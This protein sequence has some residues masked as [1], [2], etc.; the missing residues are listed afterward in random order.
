MALLL[1]FLSG[2]TSIA[3]L[4]DRSRRIEREW[5]LEYQ[6][7]ED[8]LRFRVV[9]APAIVVYEEMRRTIIDLGLP[10]V[11]ESFADGVL[12]A[13]NNAPS[14]LTKEEW[15]EVKRKEDPQMKDIGGSLLVL[16]ED[17]SNFVITLLAVVK[18]FGDISVV[19]LEYE[20]D[21]PK[22]RRMG[23]LLS[24]KAPPSAVRIASQKFWTFLQL[25]LEKLK[26][27][28]PRRRQ[29]KEFEI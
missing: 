15:L 25:R 24:R 6:K 9:E 14:P 1:L 11:R 2:C 28:P 22:Y 21:S 7:G 17:P 4:N 8:E 10:I 23:L 18:G 3:E 20:L 16:P 29:G 19:H 13:E 5:M 27:A 12:L 26:I